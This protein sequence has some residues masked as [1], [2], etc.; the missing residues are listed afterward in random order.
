MVTTTPQVS[1]GLPVFNGENFLA[2]TLNSILTQTFEDLELVVS[3]NASTDRTAEICRD[4]ASRDSRV[5]YYR[6][7]E[8]VGAAPNFN[9]VFE[10]STGEY[11]KWVAHDDRL[12][13]HYLARCVEPLDRDPSIV[14]C[15][16]RV[17]LIDAAG[18]SFAKFHID[19]GEIDSTRP[20]RRFGAVVLRD[21]YSYWV[22]GLMRASVL[23]MTPVMASY[24]ASDMPLR[25]ELALLGKFHEVPDY[26]FQSRDHAER[27]IRALPGFHMRAQWFDPRNRSRL[28][29]PNW[30]VL[31]EYVHCVRRASLSGGQRR[32]CYL[33][34][35]RFVGTHWTWARMLMDL[36]VVVAP[37]S[38]SVVRRLK[39]IKRKSAALPR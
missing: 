5:R 1:I 7:D 25:A 24:V 33:Y 37:G 28:L 19:H 8:N 18:R 3:D 16:S 32:R 26:L 12:T 29:F 10:L 20:E 6:S 23:R 9:R 14:V 4:Y 38:W 27:S 15:H 2:E 36:L 34:L 21:L 22:F 31:A 17:E 35:A 11:F 13:P 30:R 39:G